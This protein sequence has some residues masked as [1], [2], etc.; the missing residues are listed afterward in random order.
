MGY[1]ES[2]Y[3]TL[4]YA[5]QADDIE[6]PEKESINLMDYLPEYYRG[7]VTMEELQDTLGKEISRLITGTGEVLDQAFLETAAWSLARWEQELGLSTDPSK[8]LVSRREMIKAKMRGVGTTTPQ[9]I[10]RTASAFSGG[11]VSVEEVPDE[12]RF[13]VRFVGSLGIPPNMPGLIQILEEIKPA[14][15]SYEFAYTYTYW[16]SLQSLSWSAARSKTWDELRTYQ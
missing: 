16:A 11:D 9:M 15:L 10:Q 7:V 14:H 3:G 5:G 13:V 8:S 6:T 1:G 4:P 12:Y 2:L